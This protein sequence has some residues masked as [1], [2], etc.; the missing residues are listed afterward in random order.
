MNQDRFLELLNLYLDNE[1]APDELSEL[2]ADTRADPK[3]E[4]LFLEYCKI[5]KACAQIGAGFRTKASRRSLRQTVYAL[6]G[7]AA[8]F[9]LLALA[10]R[11]LVPFF[12]GGATPL[13]HESNGPAQTIEPVFAELA[14]TE[15][16]GPE[17]VASGEE[18]RILFAGL[19]KRRVPVLGLGSLF[20]SK[21]TWSSN[22][23]AFGVE[24]SLLGT[25]GIELQ[26]PF[27]EFE[28]L[29]EAVRVEL[30]K[31]GKIATPDFGEGMGLRVYHSS[32]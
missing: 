3:R 20:K 25:K 5:H 29:G 31:S 11:N 26:D 22:T 18:P 16:P 21:E 1:I 13:A 19:Q 14:T 27:K 30:A 24:E 12:E 23:V 10:G 8:A 9:A 17:F 2:M 28:D 7:M 32:Q 4:Q 15:V 6:G